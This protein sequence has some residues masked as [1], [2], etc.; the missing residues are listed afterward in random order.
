MQVV[1]EPEQRCERN[2]FLPSSDLNVN[3]KD[4][5]YRQGLT[6]DEV[7]RLEQE[8]QVLCLNLL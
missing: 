1:V 7:I 4:A 3:M 6:T 8:M 2:L 5:Q